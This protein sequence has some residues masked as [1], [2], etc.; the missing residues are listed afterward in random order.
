M[1]SMHLKR[2]RYLLT[3]QIKKVTPPPTN[4]KKK[5]DFLV[6]QPSRILVV[7]IGGFQKL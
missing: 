6:H 1:V 7:K 4:I 3:V 5:L 2:I